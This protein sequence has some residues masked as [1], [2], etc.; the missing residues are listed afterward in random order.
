MDG[1]FVGDIEVDY[2]RNGVSGEPFWTCRFTFDNNDQQGPQAFVAVLP[3]YS[4]ETDAAETLEDSR[5][6]AYT[7]WGECYVLRVRDLI[8]GQGMMHWRGDHFEANLRDAIRRAR[9]VWFDYDRDPRAHMPI[10][11]PARVGV[12]A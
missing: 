5:G 4:D 11:V 12:T 10:R 8:D 2:H 7:W 6:G 9:A 1:V 3:S